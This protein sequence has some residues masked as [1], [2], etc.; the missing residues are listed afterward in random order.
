MVGYATDDAAALRAWLIE[1]V[2]E[3]LECGADQVDPT[4]SFTEYGL[5]SMLAL[6]LCAD[7]EEHLG[8]PLEPTVVWD[9]PSVDALIAHVLADAGGRDGVP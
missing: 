6:S 2:A 1:Q 4:R 7:L 3:Y 8:T 5:H 9:H